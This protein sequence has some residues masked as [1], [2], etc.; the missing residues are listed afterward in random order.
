M[1]P[2]STNDVAGVI[3]NKFEMYMKQKE[4]N[5]CV[6]V[7]LSECVLSVH[8]WGKPLSQL[9]QPKAAQLTPRYGQHKEGTTL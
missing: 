5:V 9:S 2:L 6:T 8:S 1:H 3:I 4:H 7:T